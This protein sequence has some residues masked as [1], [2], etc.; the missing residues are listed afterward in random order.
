MTAEDY[1]LGFVWAEE[2][3]M[4]FIIMTEEDLMED[5]NY[6]SIVRADNFSR[7]L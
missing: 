7:S 6:N 2:N 4:L 3:G 5:R 1:Y